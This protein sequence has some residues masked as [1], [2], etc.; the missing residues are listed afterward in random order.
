MQKRWSCR[1]EPAAREIEFRNN[2]L[3]RDRKVA[4]ALLVLA[5]VF[6]ALSLPTDASLIADPVTLQLVWSIRGV[7]IV[8]DLAALALIRW[9]RERRI[10][11]DVMG[12][13]AALLVAGVVVANGLLP[14]DYTTH[15]AWDLLLT[16]A[17]YVV[18]PLTLR[19]QLPIAAFFTFGNLLLFAQLKTLERPAAFYDILS[20]FVCANIIGAMTSWELNRWR[21]QQFVALRSEEEAKAHLEVAL[22]EVKTLRGIIPICAHCKNVRTDQGIWRQVE[23]YVREHSEADFTHGICPD[24][25]RKYYPEVAERVLNRPKEG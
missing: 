16:L 1:L 9:R 8:F 23:S 25:M 5:M 17:V 6:H 19:R 14:R 24:C 10:F 22:Q 2:G 4:T 18:V 3:R 15:V 20:A 7:G 11:D 21:R 13:W 12:I